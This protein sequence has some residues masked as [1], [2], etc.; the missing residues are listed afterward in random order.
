MYTCTFFA[1]SDRFPFWLYSLINMPIVYWFYLLDYK[2]W[3]PF[4][5]YFLL[6]SLLILFA[7]L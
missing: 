4:W 7:E 3:F 2:F 1:I 6:N 5:L